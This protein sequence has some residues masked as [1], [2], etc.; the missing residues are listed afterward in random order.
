MV[1][2]VPVLIFLPSVCPYGGHGLF[3]V[4]PIA[5]KTIA[6]ITRLNSFIMWTNLKPTVNK[7]DLFHC[8]VFS[9]ISYYNFGRCFVLNKEIMGMHHCLKYNTVGFIR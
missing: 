3:A 2:L 7:I 4:Y 8:F 5:S 6:V 1:F 9:L